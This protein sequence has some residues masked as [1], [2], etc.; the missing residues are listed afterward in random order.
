MPLE[1]SEAAKHV[2]FGLQSPEDLVKLT[3]KKRH[4]AQARVL[5]ALGIEFRPRPDGS[6]V[7]FLN[8]TTQ[9]RP[10]S[11]KVRLPQAR[12]VLARQEG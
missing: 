11:P 3:G 1:L 5:K 7:V 12:G 9:E 8:E 10:A 2:G 6:L 4:S